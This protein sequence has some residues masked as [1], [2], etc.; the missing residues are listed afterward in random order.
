MRLHRLFS[1]AAV[2]L[3]GCS[4]GGA[5]DDTP[6]FVNGADS[7][8]G[9]GGDDGGLHF[10]D[11]GGGLGGDVSGKPPLDPTKDN[12]GDGYTYA[13]DCDDAN[14]AVNPGAYDVVGDKVDNDCDGKADEVDKCDPGLALTSKTAADYAKALDLC[15]TTTEGATGKDKRWGVI[16]ATIS[17]TDG[18][19]A[20]W[21]RQYGIETTFGSVLKPKGNA[22][23][24]VLSTGSARTPGQPD[25][26]KP[27]TLDPTDKNTGNENSAPPGWPKNSA[28]CADPL[29][30]GMA[31]DSVVLKLR[32]RV[33]TNANAFSYDFDFY[34]SEYHDYVCTAFNDTYIALLTTKAKLDPKNNGNI[35]FDKK[36]DPVNVN[37]GFFEVCSPGSFGGK[38]FACALGRT[39]LSGTGFDGDP[40]PAGG[41]ADEDGATSWLET[42][43]PVVPGE[44]IDISFMIWN[45][46]DHILQ[47]T[48]LLDNWQWSAAPTSG[49]P[50][51]DRPK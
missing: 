4:A 37:S 48:V 6:A 11:S 25:Y 42:K 34:T 9:G 10:D 15:K 27:L 7:G 51:T 50:S 45:T 46:S 38:S 12:D 28:G 20:P 14:P 19:A 1:L 47:S 36:G 33:P 41:S 30:P 40:D 18:G 21:A 26:I 2:A 5:K 16:S 32:I 43:A 22:A 29:T 23:M 39:E 49:P 13:D 24:A 3:V 17:T 44:I 31:N 35:S 8:P